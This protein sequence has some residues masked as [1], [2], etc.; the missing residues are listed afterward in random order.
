MFTLRTAALAAAAFVMAS[1]ATAAM[2]TYFGEDLATFGPPAATTNSVT[3]RDNFVAALTAYRTENFDSIAAAT[4]NPA[5]NFGGFGTATTTDA[6]ILNSNQFDAHAFSGSNY[7]WSDRSITINFAKTI[8]SFGLF[9][10]DLNEV[11]LFGLQLIDNLGNTTTL[12]VPHS[13]PIASGANMFFGFSNPG[14]SY[15]SITLLNNPA[16][17]DGFGFDDLIVGR[18]AVPEPA[19]WALMIAGFGT[20]GAAM[21]RR[22]M[23]Y[24]AF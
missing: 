21:R 5:L 16:G 20:I 6:T 3:A 13:F 10:S 18:S 23:M 19:S 12:A 14:V 1:P 11:N 7:L 8:S 4:T 22:R 15:V 9:G 2:T 17:A 24:R